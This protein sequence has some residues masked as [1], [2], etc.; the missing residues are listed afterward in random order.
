MRR[1]KDSMLDGKRLID[2]P[3]KV[4]N[5]TKLKFMQEERDIYKMVLRFHSSALAFS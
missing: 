5:L 1:M 2:L 3:P 4:V